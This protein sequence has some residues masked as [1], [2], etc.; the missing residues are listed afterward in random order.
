[1]HVRPVARAGSNRLTLTVTEAAELLGISR[2]LAYELAARGDET[3]ARLAIVVTDADPGP[4]LLAE[5]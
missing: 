3:L 5:L 2:A 4:G 1:M